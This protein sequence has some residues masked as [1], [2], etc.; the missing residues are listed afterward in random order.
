MIEKTLKDD[1]EPIISG[2]KSVKMV[3]ER[4]KARKSELFKRIEIDFDKK[5]ET[6]KTSLLEKLIQFQEIGPD[7]QK[8]II[9]YLYSIGFN[10]FDA[11]WYCL[12]EEKKW[13][14]KQ[15]ITIRD[16]HIAIEAVVNLNNKNE[17]A[18]S[19]GSGGGGSKNNNL[20]PHER[21]KFI[22]ELCET[23]VDLVTDY[24]RFGN[25][26][27]KGSLMPPK[28]VKMHSIDEFDNLVK[29]I[30]KTFSN[31]VRIAF[32]P[33]KLT[34]QDEKQLFTKWPDIKDEK[35]K[36]QILPHCVRVCR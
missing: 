13:I 1:F 33:N 18:I 7:E 24:W 23:L 27:S 14:I 31:I 20:Q 11:A 5:I 2:Y 15:I 6:V 22:E 21:N 25:L 19:G 17:A 28:G 35:I 36:S 16:N 8:I 10:Q 26:Y 30:L 34:N 3:L 29:E 9:E 4:A 12:E 32:I